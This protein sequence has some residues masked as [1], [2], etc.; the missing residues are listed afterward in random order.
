MTRLRLLTSSIAVATITP[1]LWFTAGT[2]TQASAASAMP[3][4]GVVKCDVLV[5]TPAS[6]DCLLP[7]PNNAFTKPAR[8]PTGLLVNIAPTATPENVKGVHINP[9]YQNQNDGF[10]RDGQHPELVDRKFRNCYVDQHRAV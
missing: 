10:G 2:A 6:H 9:E 8:T 4:P 1:L 7:W 5:A 3:N